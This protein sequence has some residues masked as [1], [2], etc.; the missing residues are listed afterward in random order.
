MTIY[1]GYAIVKRVPETSVYLYD[2]FT[3]EEDGRLSAKIDRAP[4]LLDAM[5]QIDSG[6][7][8]AF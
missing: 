1:K 2:I 5:A 7:R 6:F 4:G 3:L 8:L